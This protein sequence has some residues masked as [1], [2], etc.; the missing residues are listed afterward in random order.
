MDNDNSTLVVKETNLVKLVFPNHQFVF[1]PYHK[2]IKIPYFASYFNFNWLARQNS[3]EYKIYGDPETFQNIIDIFVEN[4]EAKID[5]NSNEITN[6][7]TEEGLDK[8]DYQKIYQ[9][10][11]YLGLSR[12]DL[13][14]KIIE[15]AL[16]K[17]PFHLINRHHIKSIP[18]MLLNYRGRVAGR[19]VC[20]VYALD[21][22][23]TLSSTDIH[24]YVT[25]IS[26]F[27][28]NSDTTFIFN[29]WIKRSDP[30]QLE[31]L[32]E[33]RKTPILMDFLQSMEKKH[34]ITQEALIGF[35]IFLNIGEFYVRKI[36]QV[37][38]IQQI[39]E[40]WIK[41]K[42]WLGG[43]TTQETWMMIHV[44]IGFRVIES[45]STLHF[46]RKFDRP[47]VKEDNFGH[48]WI[49]QANCIT[50]I[51][52]SDLSFIFDKEKTNTDISHGDN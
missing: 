46:Y 2:L 38:A 5:I 23:T 42:P 21:I 48:Q 17:L 4:H 15:Q 6:S 34:K 40:N 27:K 30:K 22:D 44:Y 36:R 43:D 41:H 52:L 9:L 24:N 29:Q 33:Y 20:L 37:V 49:D 26:N 31:W 39:I 19:D 3:N 51:D 25:Q 8:I 45:K 35:Y 11:D 7:E 47:K 28:L 13:D 14:H 10:A 50:L 18:D 32:F 1:Y 16:Y 12:H